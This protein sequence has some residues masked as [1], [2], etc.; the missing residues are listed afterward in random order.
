MGTA[1]YGASYNRNGLGWA[2]PNEDLVHIRT[3]EPLYFLAV[4]FPLPSDIAPR[5]A[6]IAQLEAELKAL[7]A[8]S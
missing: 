6:R 5:A 2:T 4:D 7:R 3:P 8:A 1:K